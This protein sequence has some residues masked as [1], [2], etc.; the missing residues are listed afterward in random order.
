MMNISG[1]YELVTGIFL[2]S[3]LICSSVGAML[4]GRSE[5]TDLKKI[6]LIFSL[7]PLFSISMMFLLS[8]IFLNT[9]E[10]PSFLISM[11]Y[12]L[13][14]LLPFCL[15]SGF[16]F[17]KLIC[18]ARSGNDFSPGRS[19]SVETIGG[20]VAGL[21]ISF[22]TSGFLNTYQLLLLVM[23]LSVSYVLLSYYLEKPSSKLAMRVAIALIAS[24]IILSSPDNLFRQ[25][26]LPGIKV[27]GSEDTPYGNIT[28]GQYKGEKSIY[29]N[30]RLLIYKS[31]VIEREENIHYA[32]LQSAEPKKIILISGSL[33]GQ[34]Q[35]VIKYPV[36]EVVYIERDPA[37][38][39]ATT[40]ASDTL[41]F[42]L[43][44]VNSDAFRY[45]RKAEDKADVIILSVPPPSTL[46]LNR[47]YTTEFFHA[48]KQ[49]LKDGGVFMCS[50][51]P[52]NDYFNKESVRLYS[53]IY[54][55]LSSVFRYVKPVVGNKL[56][57]IAAGKEI[58]VDFCK[59]TE[60]RNITNAY[61]GPDFLSDDLTERKS[62]EFAGLMD[63]H[64]RQ[65]RSSF[66]VA[67]YHFQLYN[68]SRDKGEKMPAMIIMILVFAAPLLLIK[69]RQMLMY[70]SA[71][72][73]AG[74]EIIIL[75]TLQIIIGNMYQLSGLV[76]AGL[77]A[78]LAAG[79]G[80]RIR[81]LN[82]ISPF[83]TGILLVLLY[84]AAGLLY[85]QLTGFRYEIP[86]VGFILLSAF[87]PALLTGKLFY[88]LT[89]GK[90]QQQAAVSV[91]SADLAGSALG[92][93]LITGVSIP[94][95]GIKVSIFILSALI[96]TGLLIGTV[97]NKL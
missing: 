49:K 13:M 41:P 30:H 80:A 64:I 76:I 40:S 93:I 5:L 37:L 9:G 88:E 72:A 28:Y 14:V 45:I 94:V 77:M 3:W 83:K 58:S 26:L 73:L 42:K 54:N 90:N 35:E 6:N 51:G 50:P 86:V 7:S 47:Y 17:I 74:F 25:I 31:D 8:R 79:S 33:E 67:S 57:F 65:N 20:V 2:G 92:F 22:L 97:K 23:L 46:Q 59:L 69:K 85:N 15:V 78:G 91:Y 1:G 10:T 84:A 81:V 53:S 96:F 75:L 71:S 56:Y 55:S 18:L 52:A 21:L 95:L 39:K 19:F 66:P 61:V 44:V 34:L 70:F 29:Y 48:V 43:S 38:A 62:E 89:S 24:V 4:A 32:M 68:F 12:T 27:T 16:T 60:M 82:G 87:F 63:S 36:S 11:I